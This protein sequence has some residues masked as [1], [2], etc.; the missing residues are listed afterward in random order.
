[1]LGWGPVWFWLRTESVVSSPWQSS[2]D[3]DGLGERL[4][5]RGV[6]D[7]VVG[8]VEGLLG[9]RCR[10]GGV[11]CGAVVGG[12]VVWVTCG[13]VG[14]F[15]VV[16]GGVVGGRARIAYLTILVAWLWWMA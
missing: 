13:E 6:G 5:C 3:G 4:L 12:R 11:G 15:R 7:L 2:A 16:G 9:V 1:M 10:A 8:C 14:V